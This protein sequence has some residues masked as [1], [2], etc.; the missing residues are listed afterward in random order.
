MC[1]VNFRHGRRSSFSLAA[2]C[3]AISAA[4]AA[5]CDYFYLFLFVRF[6]IGFGAVGCYG[7]AYTLRK[8][9]YRPKLSK[10]CMPVAILNISLVCVFISFRIACRTFENVGL[11][12]VQHFI[13]YWYDYIGWTGVLYSILENSINSYVSTHACFT[14]FLLVSLP[15]LRVLCV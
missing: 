11:L 2:L 6:L 1:F 15:F 3:F 8:F 4:F 14:I 13:C 7:T 10:F 9:A 12:C 5:F